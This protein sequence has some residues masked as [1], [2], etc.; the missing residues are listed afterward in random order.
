MYLSIPVTISHSHI[1]FSLFFSF[2][3][4]TPWQQRISTLSSG[5]GRDRHQVSRFVR[6][7][8]AISAFDWHSAIIET[9]RKSPNSSS[10][11]ERHREQQRSNVPI[12]STV[13]AGVS[14]AFHSTMSSSDLVQHHHLMQNPEGQRHVFQ[15]NTYKKITPCD[16]C[17]QVLRGI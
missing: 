17:S 16:V 11:S 7:W 1:F 3:F 2:F 8:K 13:A 4:A 9:N 12:S 6:I 10:K 5:D 15:E 14:G